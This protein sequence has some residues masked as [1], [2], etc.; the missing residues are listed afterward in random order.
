ML[1]FLTPNYDSK[2]Y[3]LETK[4]SENV[5]YPFLNSSPF[6]SVLRK[7]LLG[8]S[9]ELLFASPQA[10]PLRSVGVRLKLDFDLE[11]RIS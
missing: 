4:C 3:R 11:E 8:S 5:N 6:S 1:K 2:T 9:L 10:H 7:E